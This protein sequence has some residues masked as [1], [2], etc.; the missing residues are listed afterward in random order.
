MIWSLLKT[1]VEFKYIRDL[2]KTQVEKKI[3]FLISIYSP[4]PLQ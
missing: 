3:W 1:F 2:S 4:K